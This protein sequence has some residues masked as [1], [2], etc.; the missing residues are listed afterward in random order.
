V[1]RIVLF[2]KETDMEISPV[3]LFQEKCTPFSETVHNLAGA[4]LVVVFNLDAWPLQVFVVIQQLQ[5]PQHLLGAAAC[6]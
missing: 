4:A 5:P 1:R 2:S 6:Q 3:F